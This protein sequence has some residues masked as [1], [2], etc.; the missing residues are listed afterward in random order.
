MSLWEG[1]RTAPAQRYRGLAYRHVGEAYSDRPL[2]GLGSYRRGGRFNPPESF[3]VLYL[4]TTYACVTEE[5][6]R[7]IKVAGTDPGDLLPRVVYEYEVNLEAVLDLTD[8]STLRHLRV[9]VGELISRDRS[10]TQQIGDSASA[11]GLYQAILSYSATGVDEVLAIL[12]E[13]LQ[14]VTVISSKRWKVP[15]DI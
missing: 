13:G 4:C 5:F 11:S 2:S 15:D 14:G 7:R 10:L 8:D 9:G 1:I 12:D 6:W 3:P